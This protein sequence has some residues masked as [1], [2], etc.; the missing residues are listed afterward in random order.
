PIFIFDTTILTQLE[1]DDARVTFI[2]EQLNLIQE[3]LN[4]IG[5]SLAV[6]HGKPIEIFEKLIQEN[7]IASVYT[8]HDYEPLARKRDKAIFQLL[9]EN[10][11]EFKTAKD[12]VIFEKSEVVKD[13]G[14]PYVVYTPYSK[15]WKEKLNN[16]NLP[17]YK[18]EDLLDKIAKHH[19]SFLSLEEIDFAKSKI[20]VP[21]FDISD[22]LIKNYEETRNFP[23]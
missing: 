11:I 17:Y 9:K 23:A 19:Y 14:E 1:K 10:N 22:D 21:K 7:S 5:K 8:N 20:K 16:I 6:F 4:S 13:N 15:K 12:Q 3:K 2:H 18:S